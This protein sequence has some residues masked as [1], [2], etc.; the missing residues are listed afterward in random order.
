MVRVIHVDRQ[1]EREEGW[2]LR[3]RH[4]LSGST[5]EEDNRPKQL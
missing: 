1:V 2:F 5:G 4:N 3:L